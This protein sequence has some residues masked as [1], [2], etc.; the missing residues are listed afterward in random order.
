METISFFD[1]AENYYH[2]FLAGLLKAI[3]KYEV[4]SNRESGNGRPDIIMKSPSLRGKAF[5]MELKVAPS[6]QEMAQAGEE[7]VRQAVK[8]NYCAELEK[9]GYSDILLYGISFYKKECLVVKC[10]KADR[11]NA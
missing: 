10:H 6:F 7:A 9:E 3:G 8:Q 2:G 4:V 5:V 1:Y 11:R